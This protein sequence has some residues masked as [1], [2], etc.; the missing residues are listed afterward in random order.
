MNQAYRWVTFVGLLISSFLFC[1]ITIIA[2]GY[3]RRQGFEIGLLVP[4]VPPAVTVF[5]LVFMT[6]TSLMGLPRRI[7]LGLTFGCVLYL[8]VPILF[9]STNYYLIREDGT[10]YWGLL[11]IPAVWFWPLVL[12]GSAT[13]F[14]GINYL[15]RA[16]DNRR[17]GEP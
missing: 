2:I 11:V 10:A 16:A 7:V 5:L 17:S 8:L 13:T 14:I 1:V 3:I 12:V 4:L 15:M 9:L 6:R